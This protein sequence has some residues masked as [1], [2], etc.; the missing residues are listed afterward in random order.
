MSSSLL[1]Y[2]VFSLY[3]I[4]FQF[5]MIGSVALKPIHIFG[6]V[7]L[8][9]FLI[10]GSSLKSFLPFLFITI[11]ILFGY[12]NAIEQLEF[13]KSFVLFIMS[14]VVVCFGPQ[15]IQSITSIKKIRFFRWFFRSYQVVVAYGV[16]QFVL[17]N[18]YGS[19]ML[20]N[21]LGDYQF[22]PHYFNELFGFSRATSIFYE[23]SVFGWVTNLVISTLFVYRDRVGLENAKFYKYLVIYFTG[24]IVSLSSSAFLSLILISSTYY[25]IKNRSKTI[26]SFVFIPIVVVGVWYLSPYLRLLE[27]GRENTSGYARVVSPFLNLIEVI[28]I[29]PFFGRGLG[30]FGV[31]DNGLQYDGIIHNSVYGFVISFGLSSIALFF[32]AIR[33]FMSFVKNDKIWAVMWLNLLLIFAA[34]GSFLSLELPFVYLLI[35]TLFDLVAQ[36]KLKVM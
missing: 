26:Y 9:I 30:Q 3:F 5:F 19:D 29:Y 4:N 24:L 7:Y 32:F 11:I 6:F 35:F 15:I 10:R 28:R 14:M 13:W 27:I 16:V 34:T 33:R 21:N 36:I 23:P 22:H 2:I 18:F 12:F 17:K 25:L 31:E 8:V 1:K 20:Y